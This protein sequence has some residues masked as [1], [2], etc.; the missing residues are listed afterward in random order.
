V[1]YAK[2][3]LV[4]A[5]EWRGCATVHVIQILRPNDRL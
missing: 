1:D 5:L 2:I 4:G 3:S